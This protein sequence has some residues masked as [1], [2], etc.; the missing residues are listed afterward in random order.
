MSATLSSVAAA[1]G[2]TSRALVATRAAAL[3]VVI[4]AMSSPP[5]ANVAAALMLVAFVFVR[6]AWARLRR[7]LAEPLGRGVLLLV[8][9][10]ALGMGIALARGLPV[11]VALGGVNGW[12]HLLLLLVALAVFDEPRSRQRLSLGFVV[13]ALLAAVLATLAGMTG[14]T[15]GEMPAGVLWRN[16]VTQALLFAVG[17]FLALLLAT[18]AAWTLRWMRP[19]L[20]VAALLLIGTLLF[21]QTGRSGALA[22]GAML[23]AALLLMLRGRRLLVALLAA[24]MLGAAVFAASPVLQQRF[25]LG[26]HEMRNA[27]ELTAYTS[28]GA[29]MIIWRSTAELIGERPLLGY[30]SGGFAPAYKAHVEARYTGWRAHL[31]TDAHNQYLT[32]WAELGLPGLLALLGFIALA[33]QQGLQAGCDW[34][35]I[36]GL[37]LLAAWCATSLFSSHFQTFNE[38]HLLM[39]MLGA[40]LAR[41]AQPPSAASTAATTA[42]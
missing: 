16:P 34:A 35:R 37:A 27:S 21:T 4:G 25:A 30:G 42:S 11:Q 7:V 5:L 10:L 33:L 39:V 36:A 22:L 29:R 26:M 18:R 32:V 2:A 13:F 9:A 14:F 20:G 1:A 41:D 8:G 19:A 12:R 17:G 23:V 6:D 40:L 38:G 3:L 15:R 31:V 24:A 28:M